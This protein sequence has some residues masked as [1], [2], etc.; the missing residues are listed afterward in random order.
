MMNNSGRASISEMV[1]SSIA[2]LT[3]PAVAT[4][5]RFEKRGGVQ[6]ALIYAAVGA[7]ISGI[8]SFRSGIGGYIA[9]VIA[10]LLSI[11]LFAFLVFY[12]GRAFGGTG[13]LN[14]VIYSIA[15]FTVPLQAVSGLLNIIPVVGPIIG[16]VIGLYGIYLGYLVVRSSMNITDTGKAIGTLVLAYLIPAAVSALLLSILIGIFAATGGS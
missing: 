12:I 11:L 10:A 9:G 6:Q 4:F 1:A 14:E 5:E 7:L 16:F 15:L 13:T 3:Q 2:V 8:G